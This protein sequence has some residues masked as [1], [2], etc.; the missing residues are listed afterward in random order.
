MYIRH[1]KREGGYLDIM[2]RLSLISKPAMQL[3]IWMKNCK[4]SNHNQVILDLKNRS[5]AVKA[6]YYRILT[7]LIKAGLIIKVKNIP[8]LA[9]NVLPYSYILNPFLIRPLDDASFALWESLG[10]EVPKKEEWS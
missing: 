8:D 5:K 9:S 2:D 6:R 4:T 1:P 3:F 10:G 7:E